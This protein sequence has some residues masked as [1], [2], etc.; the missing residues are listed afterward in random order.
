MYVLLLC[1]DYKAPFLSVATQYA[2]LF[3]GSAY[4][5]VTVYLKGEPDE[6]VT[7]LSEADEVVYLNYQSKD[8]KG[9]KR[10]QIRDI[11]RLH[12]QYQFRFAIAHRYK[13]LYIASHVPNLFCMGVHHIDGDYG[14]FTRRFYANRK[15]SQ[16][17]LL[18]VS[19]A[20]R[21]DVRSYL[22]SWPEERIQHLYN[23]LDFTGIRDQLLSREA[24]REHLGFGPD[25]YIIANVGRLHNDKDQATLL[26][27]FAQVHQD[28]PGARLAI[29]GRGKLEQNLREQAALGGIEDKVSI[30]A[31]PEIYRYMRGFDSF[32]LSSIREGL[33]VAMLEAYAAEVPAI[34]SLCNGNAE[35]I[36]G[37]GASFAIGDDATL[38]QHMLTYYRMEEAEIAAMRL[39]INQ[40]IEENFTASAVR[41]AFWKLPF[42]AAYPQNG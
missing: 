32:V 35:A 15:R 22:T 29:F 14:S 24:A 38:A 41:E 17:A 10:K 30:T 34:A 11:R 6:E 2:S 16:I 7:R 33:P 1:H 18:G 8:I 39:R 3:K 13:A 20:I 42:M 21:D 37:V 31:V 40:K 4:K 27:A 12:E 26:R 36:D 25:E 5:V 9:L 19:K 23:S 28:M